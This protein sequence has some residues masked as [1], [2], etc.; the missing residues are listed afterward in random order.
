M[1]MFLTHGDDSVAIEKY[2][3][4]LFQSIYEINKSLRS[5]TLKNQKMTKSTLNVS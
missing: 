1:D 3:K 4:I 2:C 5:N